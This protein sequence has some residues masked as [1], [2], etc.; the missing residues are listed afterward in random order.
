MY[1]GLIDKQLNNAF[2]L[3]K[4]IKGFAKFT[5]KIEEFDFATST[6]QGTSEEVTLPIV[7]TKT[8]DN[9]AVIIVKVRNLPS[10]EQFD[11][12]EFDSKIWLIDEAV[13]SNRYLWTLKVH[14]HG[15]V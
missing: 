1:R 14:T 9:S 3:M 6:S 11:T 2:N 8:E 10:I 15:Q 4:D 5:K 13:K 7:V 12:V